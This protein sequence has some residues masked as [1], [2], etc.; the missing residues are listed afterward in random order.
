VLDEA[1]FGFQLISMLAGQIGG[2]LKVD[3]TDGMKVEIEF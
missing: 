1:T 2:T 3:G